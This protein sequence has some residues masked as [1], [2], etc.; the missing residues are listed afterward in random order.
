[1]SAV[2]FWAGYLRDK[3]IKK[4]RGLG[5]Q[6]LSYMLS[7]AM[8]AVFL[9]HRNLW[10]KNIKKKKIKKIR[11]LGIRRFGFRYTAV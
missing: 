8:S 9:T 10:D 7:L 1:M 2:K 4:F 5:I 6:R 11:G 3:N